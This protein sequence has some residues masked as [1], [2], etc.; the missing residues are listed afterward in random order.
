MCGIVGLVAPKMGAR[1]KDY[2]DILADLLAADSVR[3]MDSTGLV[4]VPIDRTKPA[5]V[6]KDIGPGFEFVKRKDFNDLRAMFDEPVLVIGHN[7]FATHGT[8]VQH[9][10]HPFVAGNISLVHNGVVSNKD[11]LDSGIT[12]DVDSHHIAGAIQKNGWEKAL[13]QL[14]GSAILVWHD[15]SDHTLHF[16]R[17]RSRELHLAKDKYGNLWYASEGAMLEWVAHRHNLELVGDMMCPSEFHHYSASLDAPY[18]Y[19]K[20]KFEEHK[21]KWMLQNWQEWHGDHVARR[22]RGRHT[23]KAQ[24]QA[25]ENPDLGEALPGKGHVNTTPLL[26]SCPVLACESTTPGSTAKTSPG[27]TTGNKRSPNQYIARNEHMVFNA[28]TG[29]Y[30]VI[31]RKFA[32]R[33]GTYEPVSPTKRSR[34]QQKLDEEGFELSEQVDVRPYQNGPDPGNPN[35]LCISAVYL[36]F[37]SSGPVEFRVFNSRKGNWE[38][39]D[40]YGNIRVVVTGVLEEVSK[41]GRVTVITAKPYIP[42]L[43]EMVFGPG[44]SLI[45]LDI[46][47]DIAQHGCM[48]CDSKIETKDHDRVAWDRATSSSAYSIVC[49]TCVSDLNV[50]KEDKVP[51]VNKVV[52]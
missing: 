32:N 8:V 17:T 2:F 19:T 20:T 28:E 46:F 26:K 29:Y 50:M 41:R 11:E 49:T 48:Y 43:E 18:K 31:D 33:A 4:V 24:E 5:K 23:W 39:R 35:E 7:R 3:G 47:E 21:P 25:V 27:T 14:D 45:P 9:N 12:S 15:S 51:P 22:T 30:E 40:P 10:A 36:G 13:P 42:K 52:H 16:S 1:S 37:Q 38:D 6:V 34:M 44:K